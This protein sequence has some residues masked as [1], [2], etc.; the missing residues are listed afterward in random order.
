MPDRRKLMKS[1]RRATDDYMRQLQRQQAQEGQ[2][3]DSKQGETMQMTQDEP[4]THDGPHS[5]TDGT[6]PDGGRLTGARELQEMMEN[7]R[8]TQGPA[9]EG[10]Q[11]PGEQAMEGLADSPAPKQQ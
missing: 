1:L 10:G 8:V 11:S 4:A 6:G 9:G 7:M 5:G 2:D 3:G